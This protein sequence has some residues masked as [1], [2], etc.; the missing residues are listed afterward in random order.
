M[1]GGATAVNGKPPVTTSCVPASGTLFSVGTTTVTCTATDTLARTDSCTFSVT[2]LEPPKIAL[3]TFL[4]FGDSITAGEDGRSSFDAGRF[5]R[6]VLLPVS[7]T[8][9]G[10]LERSLRSRYVAQTP[11]VDNAGKKGEAVQD[12]ET[13]PRFASLMSSAK[14]SAVLIMEGSNDLFEHDSLVIPP[15]IDKL[16]QMI[17]DAK[18]HGVRPYLA[19]IPPMNPAGS[20]GGEYSWF[21]VPDFNNSVRALAASEAVTLVDVNQAFGSNFTLLS[22]D[23]LHPSVAGYA[24]IAETFFAAIRSTIE[25]VTPPSPSPAVASIPL[26]RPR[27]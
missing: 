26:S 19:T 14:Y 4:A 2:V 16:R 7:Q 12:A 24:T 25:V 22:E 6:A 11:T 23:G 21:L 1:Y 13:F 9:P 15:A 20:R 18:R 5:H 10:V 3:T 8:Y 27:R 17:L